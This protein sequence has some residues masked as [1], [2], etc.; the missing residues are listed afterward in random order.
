MQEWLPAAGIQY[1]HF[2]A[3][4]G[5]RNKSQD[6]QHELN[7]GWNNQSFHNYADF[8]LTDVFQKGIRELTQTAHFH[9]VAYC[10]SERHPS[11]CHRLLISNWLAAN[12][13]NVYHIMESNG[14]T[15]LIPHK[16]GQWG[17]MP[18]IEDD[19]TVVYPEV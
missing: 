18:I 12:G 1:K 3:L 13:W 9:N 17:A 4:T 19:G 5:R 10:C 14:K 2:Q 16:L 15:Q 11:R 7:S 6:I 8:T